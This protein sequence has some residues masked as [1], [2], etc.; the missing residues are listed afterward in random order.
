MFLATICEPKLS[1]ETACILLYTLLSMGGP[2]FLAR[3]YLTVKDDTCEATVGPT[4]HVLS[5]DLFLES[6]TSTHSVSESIDDNP[7]HPTAYIGNTFSK[8]CTLLCHGSRM[9]HTADSKG[10]STVNSL[11]TQNSMI[12]IQDALYLI[13]LCITKQEKGDAS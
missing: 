13:V 10:L 6:L 9:T 1:R 11:H 2:R 7:G 5:A 8:P 4:N 3:C 12:Q